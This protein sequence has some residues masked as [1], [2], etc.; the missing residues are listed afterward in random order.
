MTDEIA[1]YFDLIGIVI[2]DFHIDELVFNPY[3]QFKT[4]EPTARSSLKETVDNPPL[5]PIF[6]PENGTVA[7]WLGFLR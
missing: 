4:I 1:N 5:R 3:H 6:A 7:I 2:C